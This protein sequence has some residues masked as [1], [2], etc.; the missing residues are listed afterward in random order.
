M[1]DH[2]GVKVTLEG[3]DPQIST[4]TDAAGKFSI[5][6]LLSGT[7]HITFSK[8]GFQNR[9]IFSY[10]FLGGNV[11]TFFNETPYLSQISTTK[12]TSLLVYVTEE[13]NPDT[14]LYSMIRLEFE[15]EPPSTAEQTRKLIV[16]VGSGEQVNVNDYDYK[17]SPGSTGAALIR[18]DK[19][20]SGAA[21][22]AIAYPAPGLCN[23]YY[24][25]FRE[26]YDYSCYGQPSEVVS[27]MAP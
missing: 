11:P 20:V 1:S 19:L 6:N 2:S 7:Y 9:T 12:V 5:V 24:D 17:L 10:Q 14:S 18:I 3:T 22:Y 27:F 25:P 8:P 13:N 23:P 26:L 21:Y 16:F 15:T 4:T